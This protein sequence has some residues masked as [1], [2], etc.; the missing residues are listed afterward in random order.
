VESSGR[1]KCVLEYVTIFHPKSPK[2]GLQERW[3]IGKP[4]PERLKLHRQVDVYARVF[5]KNPDYYG[6]G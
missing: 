3:W 1:N 4:H 5:L 2:Q 6:Y